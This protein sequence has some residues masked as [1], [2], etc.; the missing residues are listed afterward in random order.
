MS[1]TPPAIGPDRRGIAIFTAAAATA[2]SLVFTGCSTSPSAKPATHLTVA[3]VP[4][5]QA[6]PLFI[7]IKDGYFKREG[8]NVT[9]KITQQSTAAVSDMLHGTVQ[10]VAA[11]NY[12]SFLQAQATG[13][14]SIRILAANSRCDNGSNLVLTLPGSGITRP[15]D[16]A[17]KSIAVNINPNIQTLAVGAVLRSEGV[18]P[19]S[20]HFVTIPFPDMLAALRA[21]RVNAI[22]E[23]EPF[24]SDAEAAGAVK[25]LNGC[26]GPTAGIPLAGYFSTSSWAQQYPGTAAAFQTAIQRAQQYAAQNRSAITAV[27]PTY[28]KITA[29]VAAKVDTGIFPSSL[30]A[31][32]IQGLANLMESAG[33]I[34]S[35]LDVSPLLL[36]S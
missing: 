28:M 21:H 4:I 23:V 14:L 12:V 15:S 16:L 33:M 13:A 29:P 17:G 24:I 2:F 19:S 27:L 31:A 36:H 10:I 1:P 3:V 32:S 18:P 9:P 11:A 30:D 25:V 26:Q 22:S 5:V 35:H 7:A 34:K 20:V 8:L 6:A